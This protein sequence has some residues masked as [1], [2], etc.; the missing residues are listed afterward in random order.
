M[1]NEC[2][3]YLLIEIK[4]FINLINYKKKWCI[5]NTKYRPKIK[6]SNSKHRCIGRIWDNKNWNINKQCTNTATMENILCISCWKRKNGSGLVTEYPDENK[7]LVWY[8]HGLKKKQELFKKGQISVEN[9]KILLK[10]DIDNEIDLNKYKKTINKKKTYKKISNKKIKRMELNASKIAD[11][12]IKSYND[13]SIDD[14]EH[15]ENKLT[16]KLEEAEYW[17]NSTLTD[18]VRI[19]DN[20][21]GTKLVFAMENTPDGSFLLNKN[22]VALGEYREWED[23]DNNIADCY[24]NNSNKVLDPNSAIPLF[25]Y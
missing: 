5:D 9:L 15:I 14:I 4:N 13:D 23:V 21:N 2:Y 24:K 3:N 19:Y 20:E 1:D 6:N 18:K 16:T 7:V 8:R 17:W 10:R 25:E 11:I 12:D 22:Q